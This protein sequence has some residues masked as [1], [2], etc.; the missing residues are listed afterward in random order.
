[1]S[2]FPESTLVGLIIISYILLSIY[3]I[4]TISA[5]IACIK[6]D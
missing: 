6:L 5:N 3:N 4:I 2:L 1:M